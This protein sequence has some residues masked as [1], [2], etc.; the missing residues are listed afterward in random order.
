M[1]EDVRRLRAAHAALRRDLDLLRGSLDR[2]ADDSDPTSMA[3]QIDSLALK[4]HSWQAASFC[5]RYCAT[6]HVHH[7]I[8][9]DALFAALEAHEP[10]LRPALKE[11]VAEHLELSRL[12]DE[13][14]AAVRLLPGDR[15]TRARAAAAAERVAEKLEAH[16]AREE[17]ALLPALATMPSSI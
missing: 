15:D 8:E 5:S 12:I 11:L 1:I 13:L 4:R 10:A 14:E 7:R 6:V 9:D 17:A 16:L 2:L 3:A